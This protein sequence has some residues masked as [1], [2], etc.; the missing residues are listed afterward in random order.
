[1]VSYS[2]PLHFQL[3]C[4]LA[5]PI[6][7]CLFLSSML[8]KIKMNRYGPLPIFIFCLHW[9]FSTDWNFFILI[10]KILI[11]WPPDSATHRNSLGSL[12]KIDFPVSSWTYI[13]KA[14]EDR[15]GE[16]AWVILGSVSFPLVCWMPLGT[17]GGP[18]LDNDTL[19]KFFL[20]LEG[21]SLDFLL[22]KRLGVFFHWKN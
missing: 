17:T 13:L 11:H 16:S 6:L 14:F 2:I 5:F 10:L 4:G 8:K 22:R 1:M 3:F 15:T 20:P 9:W 21:L 18:F 19:K 12:L 7:F